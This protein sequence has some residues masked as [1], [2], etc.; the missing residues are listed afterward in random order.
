MP[1][2]VKL[3]GVGSTLGCVR[4]AQATPPSSASGA[5]GRTTGTGQSLLPAPGLNLCFRQGPSEGCGSRLYS[6]S[7]LG[8]KSIVDFGVPHAVFY[9]IDSVAKT[10]F[11]I[12][13][14]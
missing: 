13:R 10:V 5:T 14:A 12:N 2:Q 7:P 11:K 3:C 6:H 1:E 4:P 8:L 9:G